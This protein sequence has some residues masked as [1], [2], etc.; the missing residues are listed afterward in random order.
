MEALFAAIYLDGGSD[1]ARSVIISLLK[2]DIENVIKYEDYRDFKTL[3]QEITQKDN[4]K[5]PVYELI[6]E[7]GPDHNKI[8][9]VSVSIDGRVLAKGVGHSKKEAEKTAAKLAVG[10]INGN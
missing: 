9:T 10:I 4:G 7:E 3:L 6:K 2:N 1:A 8:F 5:S